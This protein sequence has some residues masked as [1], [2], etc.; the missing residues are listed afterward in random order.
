MAPG[1]QSLRIMPNVSTDNLVTDLMAERFVQHG[2]IFYRDHQEGGLPAGSRRPHDHRVQ[3]I[4]QTR[5]IE[6][7]RQF[8]KIVTVVKPLLF[9]V[10]VGAH[11]GR[12]VRLREHADEF[13]V[14]VFRH[15]AVVRLQPAF[16]GVEQRG[17]RLL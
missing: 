14:P 1:P 10:S 9:D 5:A 7:P 4:R 3:S 12:L 8:V 11:I 16:H 2:Q 6:L 15:D 13:E 17:D